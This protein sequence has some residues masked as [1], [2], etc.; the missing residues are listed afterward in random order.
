[1][2]KRIIVGVIAAAILVALIILHGW[3]MIGAV[4]LVSLAVQYEM[5][6]T[7]KAGGTRPVSPVLYSFTVL[8]FPAYYF[9]GLSGVFILQMIAVALIFVAGVIFDVFDF[10]S[11]F[12]SI[13][14]MYYPQL[15]FVFLYMIAC[16]DDVD[17][18]RVILVVTFAASVL[19][20]SFAYFVGRAC[21]KM[22]LCPRISPNKT[23]EGA[24]GGLVGGV[25]GVIG[26]VLVMGETRVP[27]IVYIF[28][29]VFLSAMA[30][31][32]DLSAS[33][34]KRRYGIKDFGSVLPGHGGLLDRLD[35]VLFILPITY[36]FYTLYLHI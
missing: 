27:L 28:L 26:A 25:L 15:F 31:V 1:M 16:M 22:K 14:T 34:V 33:V 2:V 5:I 23:V 29:A 12:S 17:L 36:L 18:S 30:Q 13:F 24:I 21:G 11:I 19:T 10:D 20:D 35:S 6:K 7:V 3:Y 8:I 9:F 4:I 32:G